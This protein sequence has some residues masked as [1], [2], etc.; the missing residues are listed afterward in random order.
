MTGWNS[1]MS[2]C[3]IIEQLKTLYGKPDTLPLFH[4]DALFHTPFLA[5]KVPEMLFCQIKQCQGIQMIAQ[6]L[7]T[8]KQI[9]VNAIRLLM[10]S[11]I[12]PLKEFDMWEAMPV[13]L[14]PILKTFIHEAYSRRLTSI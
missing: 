6:D 5:N 7:Y 14:Y 9:I 1:L 12:F 11:G 8:P 4:N 3:S 2:M 10:Q 13:K